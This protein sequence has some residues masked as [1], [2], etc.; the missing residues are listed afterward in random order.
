MNEVISAL[1]QSGV[2]VQTVDT[3]LLNSE[4]KIRVPCA[5]DDIPVQ[6]NFAADT[7]AWSDQ[8]RA[9]LQICF[10]G[11]RR[12]SIFE[13]PRGGFKVAKIVQ[14]INKELDARRLEHSKRLDELRNTRLAERKFA[15]FAGSLGVAPEAPLVLKQ[16]NFEVEGLPDTPLLVRI[17][18]RTSH[19]DAL[20]IINEY[21]QVGQRGKIA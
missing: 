10:A 18:V 1:E 2:R 21:R 14:R 9:D 17:T 3:F 16:A 5:L 13:A 11:R 19:T 6:M 8:V 7:P 20:K 15:E 12:W 4:H